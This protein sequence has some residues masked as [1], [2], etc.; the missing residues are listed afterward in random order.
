MNPAHDNGATRKRRSPEAVNLPGLLTLRL[1]A[2]YQG[3]AP[4]QA[5][6]PSWRRDPGRMARAYL[7]MGRK[8]HRLAFLRHVAGMIS[9]AGRFL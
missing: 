7:L 5:C 8:I 1:N 2:I 9:A 6:F 4:S 3:P